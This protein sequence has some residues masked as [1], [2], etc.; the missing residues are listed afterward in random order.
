MG[1]HCLRVPNIKS[2]ILVD[3]VGMGSQLIMKELL[4]NKD[5]DQLTQE[6]Q[7]TLA[8]IQ[9]IKMS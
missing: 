3:R 6:V 7:K 1:R 2:H 9:K 4:A 5:Y 8:L